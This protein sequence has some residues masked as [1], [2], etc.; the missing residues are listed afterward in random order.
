MGLGLYFAEGEGPRFERTAARRGVDRARSRCPTWRKLALR[1]RRG[2]RDQARARRPRAADRLLGQPVHARLLHD[3]RRR[4]R[5]DFATVRSMAYAR[6]DLLQRIVDVN[7]RGGRRVPQRADR[8]RRRCGDDLR[9]LGRAAVRRRVP[10]RSRS[11]RCARCCSGSRP[12]PD[13]RAR[14]DDRVHQGRRRSGSTRSP[15]AAPTASGSTGP[16]ISPH[17]RARVGGRVA[18]QGNLDPLVLLTD[19]DTVARE[20]AAVVRAAGPA[21]GH[22]FNLGHGIVPGDAARE[23]RGAGRGGPSDVAATSSPR[24]DAPGGPRRGKDAEPRASNCVAGLDKRRN[25][26]RPA[27]VMHTRMSSAR[28]RPSARPRPGHGI[29]NPLKFNNEKKCASRVPPGTAR[30]CAPRL[31]MQAGTYAQS[32]PQL[33]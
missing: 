17:A 4:Q 15:A 26:G 27:A 32:Y 16:S 24:A 31:P 3:R 8:R 14:A 22:I 1:V 2:A 7:A 13:G 21:P 28:R 29:C 12:A 25:G 11:R 23:R 19:P 33:L 6:P 18:L 10:A 30:A 5:A 9:H 20:A